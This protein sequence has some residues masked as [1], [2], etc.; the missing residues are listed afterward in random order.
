[1]TETDFGFTEGAAYE[2]FMGP[3]TRAVGAVFLDWLAVPEG[4]RWLDIGC[5]TGVF[6]ELISEKAAPSEIVAIDPAPAQILYAR[7]KPVAARADFRIADAAELPFDDAS[8]DVVASALVINFI[9]EREKAIAEMRRVTRPGGCVAGFVWDFCGALAVARH[10]TDVLR[11][12]E[13]KRRA[14]ARGEK[15]EVGSARTPVRAGRAGGC[16]AA[17]HRGRAD[18]SGY[19]R[20]LAAF[21]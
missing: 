1:M 14:H 8:F 19:R 17:R 3:W 5:G 10:V 2:R 20:L 9:P 11:E 16:G 4:Q 21:Y 6:T 15:H 18:L 13:A 12:M 7:E